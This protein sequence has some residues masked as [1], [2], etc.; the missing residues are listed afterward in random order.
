MEASVSWNTKLTFTGNARGH[1]TVMDTTLKNGG[2]NRGPSPKEILLESM[3]ACAG[4]DV[5]AILEKKNLLP[6]TL[7][8]SASAETKKTGPSVFEFVHLGFKA[9]GNTPASELIHAVELSMTKYCGVTAMITKVCPV[10]YEIFLNGEKVGEG[11]AK[12]QFEN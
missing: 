1:E 8:M 9:S 5:I 12:F 6:L 2:L 11:Q 4:I 3:C 10:T 7:D